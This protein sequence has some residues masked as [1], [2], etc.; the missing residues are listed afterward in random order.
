M[1]AKKHFEKY[2]LKLT[3]EAILKSAL[4]GL[5]FGFAACFI[6]SL[7]NWLT[8]FDGLWLSI[9]L[10]LAVTAG[11]AAIFYFKRFKLTA[12]SNARRIDR[13]GLEERIITMIEYEG[14]ESFIAQAQRRDAKAKLA[15]VEAS[16]LKF[17]IP[18]KMII[19]AAIALVLG[20]AMTTVAT[21]G[22]IGILPGGD[23]MIDALIPDEP[24]TYV[25]ISYVAEG[26]GYIEGNEEQL[27]PLGG[28][29]ETV[30]AVP[31]DGYIFLGW[32]DGSKKPV[33]T[34]KAPETDIVYTAV[35]FLM[36]GGDG[37][38]EGDQ[39]GDRD[40]DQDGNKPQKGKGQR[41][42]EEGDSNDA[43]FGGGKYEDCNQVIDG[44]TYYREIKGSY[45]EALV[46]ALE[47]DS[48]L[49]PEMKSIIE[50]Y[51]EIV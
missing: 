38:G 40:G 9:G 48:S 23:E 24:V 18:V 32:D 5:V 6:A 47:G 4:C 17:D 14:D 7:V 30:I 11:V 44:E 12:M 26:D 16:Q 39:E 31:D 1:N 28:V 42:S 20:A 37:D 45:Q 35:F 27:V 2:Y 51:I 34:D 19:A 33:R 29:G 15:E 50:S 25:S 36:G 41:P 3:L 49:T 46:E 8:G 13:L 22:E 43:D 10:L 21:L